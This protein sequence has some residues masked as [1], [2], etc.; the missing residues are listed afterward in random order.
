MLLSTLS[1]TTATH[2][3][4]ESARAPFSVSSW[5]RNAAAHLITATKRQDEHLTPVLTSLHWLLVSF[6]TDFN[7]VFLT[8]KACVPGMCP[9]PP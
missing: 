8:F 2:L 1:L 3:I 4:W 9:L 7:I 5:F 6:H